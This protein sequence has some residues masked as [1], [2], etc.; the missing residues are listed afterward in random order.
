MQTGGGGYDLKDTMRQ[1]IRLMAMESSERGLMPEVENVLAT[2]VH[3]SLM[4][5]KPIITQPKQIHKP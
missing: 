3:D 5:L 1:W 2:A 4:I